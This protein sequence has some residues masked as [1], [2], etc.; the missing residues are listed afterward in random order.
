MNGINIA[1]VIIWGIAGVLTLIHG[2]ITK[3][4]FIL[5][6]SVLMLNFIDKCFV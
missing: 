3:I 2:N 4:D 5:V 1:N 6:W